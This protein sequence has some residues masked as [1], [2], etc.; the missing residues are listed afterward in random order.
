MPVYTPLREE[1][2]QTTLFNKKV[3]SRKQ[4][5]ISPLWNLNPLRRPLGLELELVPVGKINLGSLSKFVQITLVR[6]GSLTPGGQEMVVS[7]LVGDLFIQGVNDLATML[8]NG[9]S[10]VDKS[11]GFHV[12]VGATDYTPYD[13]RRLIWIVKTIQS[14]IYAYLVAPGRSEGRYCRP[15]NQNDRWYEDL[16]DLKEGKEIR[17]YLYNWLYSGARAHSW[18]N[19]SGNPKLEKGSPK[20]IY[21]PR[22]SILNQEEVKYAKENYNIPMSRGHKYE[23][24]RY[25][26]V[27][28][29]SWLQRGTVEFRHHQGTVTLSEMTFWPLFCGWVV[30]LA[31]FLRDEEVREVGGLRELFTNVWKRPFK[32]LEVPKAVREWVLGK[33]E[34]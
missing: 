15:Y 6:D 24:C 4:K 20:V 1:I 8:A 23:T 7:P 11:C 21:S 17:A 19:P 22:G 32:T 13:L 27:N 5:L 31:S 33:L 29:H 16:W 10:G 25:Y 18:R 34:D 28:I 30:E 12:H 2:S 26:G 14:D 3:T 9:G